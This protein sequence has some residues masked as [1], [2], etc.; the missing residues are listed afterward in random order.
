MGSEVYGVIMAGGAGTR[1]WPL[2]R[3]R[4]PK[5][6][7]RLSGERTLLEETILRL[8]NLIPMER[9]FIVTTPSCARAM[10]IH[11]P[12]VREH[13]RGNL[14]LEPCGRNTAPALGLSAIHL[15]QKDPGAIMIALPSDHMIRGSDHFFRALEVGRE[16]AEEGYLVTIGIRPTRPETGYG[17]IKVKG[18]ISPERGV[19]P[20]RVERF[21]EKP[22]LRR[23]KR[24]LSQ[25]NYLWNSGI[26]IWK[27]PV[28]LKELERYMPD[29]YR[30]LTR[31]E[32]ALKEG[33][34]PTIERLY[35]E[36]EPI[37]VD[38][39][40]MERSRKVMV[41]P[42]FFQWNDVG[43][44]KALEEIMEKD[45]MGNVVRG[46]VIAMDTKNSIIFGGE[47]LL[48]T[49]GI[50]DMVVVDTEDATL[51]CPK[52]RAQD[53]RK[54]VEELNRMGSEHSIIHWKMERPWGSSTLLM[55]EE[56]LLL[57]RITIK[58]GSSL[59]PK[60]EGMEG[61]FILLRGRVRISKGGNVCEKVSDGGL[62]SLGDIDEIENPMGR[63]VHLLEVLSN[64]KVLEEAKIH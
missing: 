22:S 20:Y 33:D 17:Y 48:A 6:L 23:A 42:G 54:V 10:M 45:G 62:L 34:L 14:I 57:R 58:A 32:E 47:R 11:A 49:I 60:E 53:V 18:G 13:L 39:G 12:L 46:N 24:F 37:S 43:S 52:D 30:A 25:G 50:E 8:R 55:K 63:P 5:Q 26:F 35:R 36:I 27:I 29:L 16:K 31:I 51:I 2:S 38:Y 59:K 28:F 9:L 61:D 7:L 4:L 44:W 21:V 15:K 1:F 56:G 19:I 3:E 41:V 40:V 64:S